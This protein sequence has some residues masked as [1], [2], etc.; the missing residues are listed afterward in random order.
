MQFIIIVRKFDLKINERLFHENLNTCQ[1]VNKDYFLRQKWFLT[2]F[3]VLKKKENLETEFAVHV[4]KD[5][6]FF[7]RSIPIKISSNF[8]IIKLST[9]FSQTHVTYCVYLSQNNFFVR[10]KNVNNIINI[11]FNVWILHW[12]NFGL[13]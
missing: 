8:W 1:K 3:W 2:S 12:R 11:E 9:E 13:R 4:L 7:Y 5:R 6:N 10:H